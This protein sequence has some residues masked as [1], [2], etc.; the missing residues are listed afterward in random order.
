MLAARL[1]LMGAQQR[2]LHVLPSSSAHRSWDSGLVWRCRAFVAP[3]RPMRRFQQRT[4]ARARIRI[5]CTR[6]AAGWTRL[7]QAAFKVGTV[8][9][10]MLRILVQLFQHQSSG[11]LQ[12]IGSHFMIQGTQQDTLSVNE[13]PEGIVQLFTVVQAASSAII[14]NPPHCKASCGRGH[15]CST[16]GAEPLQ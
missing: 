11:L 14:A 2:R 5:I 9:S 12:T 15:V 6:F 13:L 7:R 8:G 3:A 10:K 4:L 1:W 16:A